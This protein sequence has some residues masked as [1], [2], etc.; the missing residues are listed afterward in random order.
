MITD[1]RYIES[2]L[3]A[4]TKR[5]LERDSA[6]TYQEVEGVSFEGVTVERDDERPVVAL[7]FRSDARPGILFGRMWPL[8]EED[9]TPSEDLE[10]AFIDIIEGL[11]SG[12]GLPA[13]ECCVL[14]ARGVVWV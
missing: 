6:R 13:Q 5:F 1:S 10:F 9:G 11:E 12:P 2:T 3:Q 8:F 7:F 4:F 14:D